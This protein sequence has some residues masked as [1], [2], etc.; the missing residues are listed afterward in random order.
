MRLREAK[1]RNEKEREVKKVMSMNI[2]KA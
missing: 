1:K 2:Q